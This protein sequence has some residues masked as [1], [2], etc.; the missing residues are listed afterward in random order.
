M[1]TL[2]DVYQNSSRFN[3]RTWVGTY[4]TREA[5][6]EGIVKMRRNS[7]S[8]GVFHFTFDLEERQVN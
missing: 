3:T 1:R 7:E 2:F 8:V 5:A 4:I 6:A